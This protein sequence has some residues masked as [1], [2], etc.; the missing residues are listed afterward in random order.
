MK[1]ISQQ[2]RKLQIP[3]LAVFGVWLAVSLAGLSCETIDNIS[4]FAVCHSYCD[5][6]ADCD[7]QELSNDEDDACVSDCRDSIEDNCGNEH[8]DAANDKM[9][10]C[11]DKS[12]DEFWTCMVFETAPECFGFVNH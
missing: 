1:S 2:T 3:V 5:K 12:C 7:N 8:Q 9:N 6:K 11:V 4:S 10:E